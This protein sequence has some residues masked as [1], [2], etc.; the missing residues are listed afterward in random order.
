MHKEIRDFLSLQAK[1]SGAFNFFING[2]AASLIYHKADTVPT[3]MVSLVIDLTLTCLFTFMINALFCSANLKSCKLA[4]ILPGRN[5]LFKF[6]SRLFRK[7]LL[8]GAVIGFAASAA[9]FLLVAPIFAFLGLNTLP[10]GV[11]ITLKVLFCAPL[12]G[13]ATLLELYSG[14]CRA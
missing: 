3:D 8:F 2:M 7:P 10:F 1:V 11:Y 13:A 6:L 4:G 5:K 14:M 9:L 12:G